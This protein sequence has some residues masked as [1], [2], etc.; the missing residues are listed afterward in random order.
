MFIFKKRLFLFLLVLASFALGLFFILYGHFF[1]HNE[2]V[3]KINNK[4]I[5]VELAQSNEEAYRGLSFRKELCSDCGMLFIFPEARER[6]FVMRNMLI[7]LDIIFIRDNQIIN[8]HKNLPPE[9]ENYKGRYS[10][11]GPA[12]Y[13]LEVNAGLSDSFGIKKGDELSINL[14]K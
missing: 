12:N 3:V 13:V 11:Q 5:K 8:I 10:S 4:K 14:I 2:N 1:A 9:G 6:T 7:P